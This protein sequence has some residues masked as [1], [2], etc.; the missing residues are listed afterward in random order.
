[1]RREKYLKTEIN[2]ISIRRE[3]ARR[4][5]ESVWSMPAGSVP[6]I[7]DMSWLN[8]FRMVPES[9]EAKNAWGAL[10]SNDRSE[11]FFL[12]QRKGKMQLTPLLCLVGPGEAADLSTGR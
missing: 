10:G 1:M 9:V 2:F 5:L 3:R 12:G 11:S 7:K 8:L 4:L 6:S